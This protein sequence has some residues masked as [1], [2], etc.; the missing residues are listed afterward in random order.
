MDNLAAVIVGGAIGIVS[1]VVGTVLA[2]YL[3]GRRRS[4]EQREALH[5][6][7]GQQASLRRRVHEVAASDLIV[8]HL[9]DTAALEELLRHNPSLFA[10]LT[11]YLDTTN[12]ECSALMAESDRLAE[13]IRMARAQAATAERQAEAMRLKVHKLREESHTTAVSTRN[14]SGSLEE[15][16]S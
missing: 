11:G 5:R 4:R 8:K 14:H 6:L 12:R 3:G 2:D 7:L 10:F 15:D 16:D 9:D 13:K 1:A